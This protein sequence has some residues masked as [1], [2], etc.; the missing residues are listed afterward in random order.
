ML[1]ISIVI[2]VYNVE[3]YLRECLDSLLN[4]TFKDFE[5]IC[6]DD[7][8]TDSSYK[9]LEE[10]KNKD[11]RLIVVQQENQGA[12]VARNK[13]IEIAN[14]KY[15]QFLDSDDV[16]EPNMLETLYEEAIANNS[17]MV[18]CS[19]KKIDEEG[20][21]VEHSNDVTPIDLNLCPLNRNF[22]WKDYPKDIFSLFNSAPWNK[23]YLKS[24]ID[25]NNLK[26]QNLSSCNDLGFVRIAKVCAQ[27]I[28]VI[29]D[30]LIS[31]RYNRKG[32]I[33]NN[34]SQKVINVLR[35]GEYIKEFLYKNDLYNELEDAYWWAMKKSVNWELSLC[36]DEQYGNFIKEA[37]SLY[38]DFI[39]RY[40]SVLRKDYIT[41]DFFD[42]FIG[43][44]KVLLWGASIFLENLLIQETE[45]NSKI[46][47]IVDKN[48]N[49]WGSKLARYEIV[50]PDKIKQLNPD[51]ILVT[52][53]SGYERIYP[54]IERYILENYPNIELLPNIFE[55]N[56]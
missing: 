6:I 54:Q 32:S 18:V 53:L 39:K 23:L 40:S 34:R 10:Y 19:A 41:Y 24:L 33:A 4:Q 36:N 56:E 38:P 55:V 20:N 50:S 49:R 13:G 45:K 51:A 3:K 7:G 52:I 47:G 21:I 12:A 46:L 31:Y 43:N 42:N 25:E 8:S 9:I 37:K 44:K 27:R 30:E 29:T 15:I 5:I 2:P 11:E 35:A 16:F 17:D 14:G 48:S 26:F 28:F 22:S 1:S